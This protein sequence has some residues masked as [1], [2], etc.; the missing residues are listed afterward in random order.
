VYFGSP[1]ASGSIDTF[2]ITV[3]YRLTD[4]Y[5]LHILGISVMNLSLI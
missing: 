4:S 2:A 3:S 1:V 5:W